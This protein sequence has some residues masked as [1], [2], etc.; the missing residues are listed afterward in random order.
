MSC[1]SAVDDAQTFMYGAKNDHMLAVA[2][3]RRKACPG[4]P[5]VTDHDPKNKDQKRT[6]IQSTDRSDGRQEARGMFHS[7]HEVR[8]VNKSDRHD[9]EA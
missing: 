8:N 9:S 2:T 6:L 7:G 1:N 4:H 5:L 3:F